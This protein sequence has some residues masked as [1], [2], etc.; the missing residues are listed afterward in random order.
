MLHTA[1]AR[2]ALRVEELPPSKLSEVISF[3]QIVACPG[4]TLL[5]LG[6]GWLWHVR[7]IVGTAARTDEST[8]FQN[9]IFTFRRAISTSVRRHILCAVGVRRD[10]AP[11]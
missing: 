1:G 11:C 9:S 7:F 8:C 2:H 5:G 6:Q 4:G 10:V 3:E